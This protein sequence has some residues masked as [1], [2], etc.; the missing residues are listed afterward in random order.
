[1]VKGL[2]EDFERRG[3]APA[4]SP[5]EAGAARRAGTDV[6]IVDTGGEGTRAQARVAANISPQARENLAEFTQG[7]FHGQAERIGRRIRSFIGGGNTAEDLELIKSMARKQNA[8]AYKRAYAAVPQVPITQELS[9]L[10]STPDVQN[11]IRQAIGSS[12]SRAVAEG[13]S[14][15]ASK[16]QVDADGKILN[17]PL[18]DT[19]FWDY[20]QRELRGM[21]TKAKGAGLR[22]LWLSDQHSAAAARR[23]GQDQ[24]GLCRRARGSGEVFQGW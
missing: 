10:T 8:P 9:R 24:S 22:S 13:F 20:V 15:Y 17:L 23:T 6:R 4:I 7:R 19:Q 16:L 21:A 14:G 1:V 12:Q 3:G 2:G 18:A 5:E 11:A